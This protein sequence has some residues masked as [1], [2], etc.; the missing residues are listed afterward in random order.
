MRR[1]V[2]VA[3]LLSSM[4]CPFIGVP[5]LAQVDFGSV[6]IGGSTTATVTVTF[7]LAGTLLTSAVF[8]GGTPN[9]DF[10]DAGGGTCAIGTAYA[11]NATCT[12]QAHFDRRVARS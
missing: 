8:T 3:L 2:K 4:L 1:G 12:V 6:N 10:T 7:P 5:L 11:A 9:L